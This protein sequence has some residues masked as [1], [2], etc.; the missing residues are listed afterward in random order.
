MS[1]AGVSED[2]QTR[3][4]AQMSPFVLNSY[5]CLS[6]LFPLVILPLLA[7]LILSWHRWPQSEDLTSFPKVALSQCCKYLTYERFG[8]DGENS[9]RGKWNTWFLILDALV[10]KVHWPLSVTRNLRQGFPTPSSTLL[11]QRTFPHPFL[12]SV[13][14]CKILLPLGCLEGEKI[15]KIPLFC[16]PSCRLWTIFFFYLNCYLRWGSGI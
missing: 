1:S 2:P 4:F 3:L 14:I 11:F 16:I 6:D 8:G 12:I 13:S 7:T 5:S 10:P 9:K 15:I